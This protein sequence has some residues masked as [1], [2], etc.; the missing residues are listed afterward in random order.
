MNQMMK[1]GLLGLVM[2]PLLLLAGCAPPAADRPATYPV[3]G[4]VTYKGEPVADAN[5]NFQLAGGS[6]YAVGKTDAAGK[7]TLMTFVDGDGALPGEYKVAIT[8]FE[9]TAQASA[10]PDTSEEYAPAEQSEEAA[11][12]KNLLP[13]KYANSET[14]GLTATVTEGPSTADFELTD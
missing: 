10:A 14:S 3:T 11:P 9:Q 5:V 6:G 13:A 7:Y 1:C 2:G 4:V 8:K 12:A